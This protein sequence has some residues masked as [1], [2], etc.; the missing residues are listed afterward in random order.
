MFFFILPASS[1]SFRS[2]TVFQACY[3]DWNNHYPVDSAIR[4]SYNRP[5]VKKEWVLMRVEKREFAW[6]GVFSTLVLRSNENKS[7][8]RVDESWLNIT[9]R[10]AKTLIK[11]WT[12]SKLMRVHESR[13]EWAVKREQKLQLSFLVWPRINVSVFSRETSFRT[14]QFIMNVRKTWY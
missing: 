10:V 2:F 14:W 13:W 5:Q 3:K 11:I 7:C 9:A 1:I 12:S 6:D 8:M 4:A